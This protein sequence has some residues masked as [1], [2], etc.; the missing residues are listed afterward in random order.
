MQ[1]VSWFMCWEAY[2]LYQPKLLKILKSQIFTILYILH[3]KIEVPHYY[4]GIT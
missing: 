3:M 1:G 4:V 2:M